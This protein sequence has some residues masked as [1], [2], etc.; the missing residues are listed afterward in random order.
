MSMGCADPL[1]YAYDVGQRLWS[2]QS[3]DAA[4]CGQTEDSGTG[5]TAR[6]GRAM[7]ATGPGPRDFLQ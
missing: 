1:K 2:S 7:G 4:G 6:A 5:Q 3:L